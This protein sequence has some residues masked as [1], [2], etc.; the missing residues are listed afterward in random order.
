MLHPK[1][2]IFSV[3]N[4]VN[5]VIW[6]L[7]LALTVGNAIN[8]SR[9]VNMLQWEFFV[10]LLIAGFSVLISLLNLYVLKNFFPEKA[11]RGS[12]NITYTTGIVFWFTLIPVLLFIF[13]FGFYEEFINPEQKGS[14]GGKIALVIIITI[15]TNLLFVLI[16]QIK[17]K[18]FLS[19]RQQLS[20]DDMIQSIGSEI[21]NNE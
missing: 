19:K 1:W 10:F 17:L 6:V 4:Y 13:C 21:N 18:R 2:K 9:Y 3:S 7:V 11:L 16:W 15:V 20:L 8:N 5:I 12:V 14:A